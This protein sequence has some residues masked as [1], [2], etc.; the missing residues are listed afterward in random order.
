MASF[1]VF[2]VVS[3]IAAGGGDSGRDAG[4]QGKFFA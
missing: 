1:S 2:S 4:R 3:G